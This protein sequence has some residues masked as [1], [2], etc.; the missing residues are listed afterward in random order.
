MKVKAISLSEATLVWDKGDFPKKIYVK[1]FAGDD[2]A[3]SNCELDAKMAGTGQFF[4]EA[5]VRA[6]GALEIERLKKLGKYKS[7]SLYEDKMYGQPRDLVD[8]SIEDTEGKELVEELLHP[9]RPQD[10][11][12]YPQKPILKVY[13]GEC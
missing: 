3:P 6:R 13:K 9:K 2:P 12:K 5:D 4:L 1:R 11:D 7:L 10:K 8:N